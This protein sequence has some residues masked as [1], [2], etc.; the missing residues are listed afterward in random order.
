MGYFNKWLGIYGDIDKTIIN[1]LGKCFVFK[2]AD[3][4]YLRKNQRKLL[5]ELNKK[6]DLLLADSANINRV[7]KENISTAL[8]HKETFSPFKNIHNG[9]DIVLVATGPTSK[10]FEEFRQNHKDAIYIGV[11][12]AC[13]I[14]DIE[15]DYYFSHDYDAIKDFID[16]VVDFKPKRE[17]FLGLTLEF[18]KKSISRVIPEHYAIKA[19]AKR[20]RTDWCDLREFEPQ[21]VYDI[22]SRAL[23]CHCSVIFAAAQFAL[24]TNPKR[25]YLIGCDCSLNGYF[26]NTKQF[27]KLS[28]D[29]VI[30]GWEKF[31]NFKNTYYP[32]TEIISINP[33]GLKGLFKD[34]FTQS[35]LKELEKCK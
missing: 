27:R 13:L 23:C 6:A 4:K 31:K 18:S 25:I 28:V 16:K 5:V 10:Y 34:D 1:F 9:K 22:D 24:W 11:N 33:V 19:K 2:E 3:K 35:Y 7:I 29:K 32:E 30:E 8:L 21:F 26:D 17:K 20:Y 15:L 12:K 14:K